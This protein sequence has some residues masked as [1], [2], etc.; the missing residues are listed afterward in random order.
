[1]RKTTYSALRERLLYTLALLLSILVGAMIG[2]GNKPLMEVATAVVAC[3]VLA[4]PITRLL[5][6]VSTVRGFFSIELPILLLVASTLG[7]RQ[8]STGSLQQNALDSVAALRLGLV[9]LSLVIATSL[10][11]R[12]RTS[13]KSV[14]SLPGAYYVFCIYIVVAGCGAAF[15]TS[16]SLALYRVFELSAA[17]LV[18]L[19]I[20]WQGNEAVQRSF[21]LI[22]WVMCALI[23]SVWLG[24]LL[25]PS[26][27]LVA[28]S[29]PIP[30]Q[31]QGVI[32]SIAS[33]GVGTLGGLVALW[34]AA[35]LLDRSDWLSR[36]VAVVWMLVGAATL[37]AAQYRTG[38]A[39]AAAGL[40]VLLF[41][42][43][44][45]ALAGVALLGTIAVVTFGGS[46]V[47]RTEP[48][49]LRGDPVALASQLSGRATYW[50]LAIPV[51]RSSPLVGRG[52]SSASRLDVLG[53]A[54]FT[55]T[56]TVH[57]TWVEALVG[58]GAIGAGLLGLFLL[59]TLMK[60]IY[61]GVRRRVSSS[62][63]VI[64]AFIVIRSITGTTIE[65]FS[66]NTLLV[67]TVVL[68]MS[69]AAATA[70]TR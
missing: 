60:A 9:L 8:R 58:A 55:D 66:L 57:S 44:R 70:R 27:A 3:V 4:P 52:L 21:H 25:V 17:V 37:V 33:N 10:L 20:W 50:E 47:A 13:E 31:I 59:I 65:I 2:S 63:A 24:V 48:V 62:A 53:P 12:P 18:L 56:S 14:V 5:S 19:S 30:T 16:T 67:L 34:S 42:R 36:R 15:A 68:A 40:S 28:V 39:A 7:Y 49:L 46:L 41:M 51:W 54:G 6:R 64:V 35:E 23:A 45:V 69:R 1:M 32:P 22:Y 11:M 29:S 61:L 26:R 38:Y 43:G